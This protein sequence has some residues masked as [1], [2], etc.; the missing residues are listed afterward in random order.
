[1]NVRWRWLALGFV[2]LAAAVIAVSAPLA[3]LVFTGGGCVSI[4]LGLLEVSEAQDRRIPPLASASWAEWREAAALTTPG[5]FLLGL[6]PGSGRR[7]YLGEEQFSGHVLVLGPSRVGKTA[8]SI[9]S[10][11]LLRDP[12]R[13]SIVVMDVKTG[14]R[15]LWSVTAGRYG[16]RARLFCPLFE[17]SV[18]YNPLEDV[19]SIG[20]AQRKA[21][22]LIHNT[23]P[24][25]LSG[26]ARV[27]AG[28]ARDLAALLFL[29]VQQDRAAGGHTVAAAYRLVLSGAAAIRETLRTSRI[30]EV[31]EHCGMFA[32][33]ER[34]V[35]EAAVTGLL[36]RLSSWAD[37]L[38]C[39]AT[40]AHWDLGQLGREPSALYIL[41]PEDEAQRLQPLV[42]W[43]VADMLDGLT[44]QA[45][46]EGLR[47]P[48]RVYLDEFRR[49][50]YLAG[51]SDRLPTLRE[52]RISVVLGAQV[53]SQ[54][55]EVYG[56]RDARTIVANAETKV[57]FRAG[58]LET[59]RMISAWLGSTCVSSV[60]VTS[61]ARAGVTTTVRPH[62]RPLAAPEEL[63]R[64]PER[65][66][67]VL[68]G[69][70]RPLALRQARY[71]EMPD[72]TVSAPPFP[73]RWRVLPDLA[74]RSPAPAS[75]E[76]R[77]ARVPRRFP[78]P[79][80]LGGVRP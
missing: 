23:T 22:L 60:S 78:A 32:A 52:R 39:D 33:R 74:G 59:A 62:V 54:I 18:S 4:L 63:G 45:D 71:F 57:I 51:L 5:P 20:A 65:A 7:L 24:R 36:E 75:A 12:A 1:M 66:V 15:A 49:F 47:C 67:I 26:D 27:Y 55:E 40:S 44:T 37:P 77:R 31:R 11:I 38:V 35:Q 41:L 70:V 73:L 21:G 43:L 61:G 58:D 19:H 30:A 79:R 29:H 53:L 46:H 68:T 2:C 16:D 34:R 10:N 48:V 72:L 6:W 9:A 64:L 14:P 50:G 42:A 76:A 28:A 13:E 17:G 8:G 56:P 69:A 3:S 80:P 25:D